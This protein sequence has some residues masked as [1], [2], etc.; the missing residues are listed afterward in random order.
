MLSIILLPLIVCTQVPAGMPSRGADANSP[1]AITIQERSAQF[2]QGTP[3]TLPADAYRPE[4]DYQSELR[5]QVN[6][7]ELI[8]RIN[9]VLPELSPEQRD[10]LDRLSEL[11]VSAQ[12]YVR[13]F[14]EFARHFEAGKDDPNQYQDIA[15]RIRTQAQLGMRL[16]QPLQRYIRAKIKEA[17]PTFT[18]AQI[19]QEENRMT[20]DILA[21]GQPV[22]LAALSEFV[23]TE[24]AAIIRQAS[25]DSQA[26][27]EAGSVF[28]RMRAGILQPG[29]AT[30]PLHI[31]NYDTLLDADVVQEPRI[32]FRMSKEDRDR[33][34]RETKVNAEFVQFVKDVQDRQSDVS[35]SFE[36]L[37]SDL[38]SDLKTWRQHT[39]R[40]DQ[41][42]QRLQAIIAA[43]HKAE[44]STRLTPDQKKL[45]GV[46]RSTLT[47][48][49]N[50]VQKFRDA[51]N[52]IVDSSNP[53]ADPAAV[54]L[55]T[56][57]A[58]STGL[59]ELQ[60]G[61][62]SVAADIHRTLRELEELWK[63][64]DDVT[65]RDPNLRDIA[66]VFEVSAAAPSTAESVR[67][68]LQVTFERYPALMAELQ[69]ASNNA[70]TAAAASRLP[71]IESDPNLLDIK[72]DEAPEGS[73][74][75]WRNLPRGDEIV[76]L[77]VALVSRRDPT[78]V[79]Q[80]QPVLHQEF[81]IEKFGFVSRWSADSIFVKR[82]GDLDPNERDVRFS[83]APAV[84]WTLHYNPPP[85]DPLH[86]NTLWDL[87]YPGIGLD[88]AALDF[89]DSGVQVGIGGHATIFHDLLIVGGGVNLH[90]SHHGGY[91]FVGLG[92]FE[93]LNQLGA[94]GAGFPL[95]R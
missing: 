1:S 39:S 21:P 46:A 57:E 61:P 74:A 17:H 82:L 26:V 44:S 41:L 6:S 23:S 66:A 36:A 64:V 77:D 12:A 5:I 90:E 92:L 76:T 93:A 34:A 83:P 47:V 85:D 86:R 22:D 19:V 95:G 43:L 71:P 48:A 54:L 62:Q 45:A 59:A 53:E 65:A 58:I 84:S 75:L 37:L 38:R 10:R 73:L 78:T 35:R 11:L 20:A 24:S 27:R 42:Q 25:K 40:L 80:V 18:Q 13:S 52:T 33:L 68:L 49:A 60:Q 55:T 94:A 31:R 28:L 51:I 14:D 91:F 29:Q 30:V 32:S 16:F 69:N 2:Y 87:L 72:V 50:H 4:V 63:N 81:D 3:R 56:A 15:A 89:G 7:D 8:G 9:S 88:V 79:L 67:S 70:R